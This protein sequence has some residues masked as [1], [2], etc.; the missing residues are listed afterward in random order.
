MRVPLL[1]L[2]AQHGPIRAELRQT[3]E[4]VLDSGAYILG[5]RV[6]QFE[7]QIADYLGASHGVGVSSGTDALLV[8]LMA[9]DVGPGDTVVTSPYSFFASAGVIARLGARP[10]FVDI[11]R[12]TFN[13]DPARLD[14][15]LSG[16]Q[17][18]AATREGRL[19][20][21]LPVSLFGQSADMGPISEIAARYSI[22][23]IE[24]AA[25]AL[26]ATYP[27]LGVVRRVGTIGAMGCYSF[28][29]SKNLGCLGDGGMVVTGDAALAE[30]L[31]K[32]RN[33]GAHPKYYHALLG[34]NFR[35]DAL[36]AA[37]LGV[38][39]PRLDGW[40][41]ARRRNAA[42]YD[43]RLRSEFVT[44]PA[45]AFGPD[46]HI[47]NQYVISVRER[48]DELRAFLT[49][50]GVGCEVYY[51]L[52]FHEQEVFR[53]LGYRVGDFPNSEF[54]ARHTLALPIYPELT[55]QMQDFVIECIGAF[56]EGAGLRGRSGPLG[57]EPHPRPARAGLP[58][59]CG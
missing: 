35:L 50:Q 27:T 55:P 28:F 37:V 6:A 16:V 48:R 14:E 52:P 58:G 12:A 26:G 7:R 30:K 17:G 51:P 42:Y 43:L 21:I 54:A 46:H 2:S 8:A 56:Y 45:T 39:L 9:L 40:S 32:L 11:D 23:L 53:G 36:Q 18:R 38:K 22:P 15:W 34:G 57:S 24:D 1:D 47:Y 49:E 29:P 41:A 3:L 33:H 44:P 25:Q 19:K 5:P 31:R 10:V 4:E 59:G 13:M 20:A